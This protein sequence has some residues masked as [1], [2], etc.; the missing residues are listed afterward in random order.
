MFRRVGVAV[1]CLLVT[2]LGF[3]IARAHH[4]A[5]LQSERVV[6]ENARVRVVEH[7]SQP[8]GDVCGVGSHTHGP[9]LTIVLSAA[10]DRV[11]NA[12]GK[13]VES[14]MKMGD[15]FWSDGET[16]TDVNIGKTRSRLIVVELK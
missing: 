1:L 7:T 5:A 6:L 10:R 9:H 16:H 8:R 12:G 4:T 11:T 3:A 13:P 15:V 14:D 2:V